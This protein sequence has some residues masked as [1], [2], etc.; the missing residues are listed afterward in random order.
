MTLKKPLAN[1]TIIPIIFSAVYKQHNLES[2]T[3]INH[4]ADSERNCIVKEVSHF[5]T[6]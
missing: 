4:F 2:T 6:K 1:F 5:Y 3:R